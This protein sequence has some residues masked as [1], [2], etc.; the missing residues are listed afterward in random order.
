MTEHTKLKS[1]YGRDLAKL[2]ADKV[3]SIFPKFQKLKFI[4]RVDKNTKDLELKARVEVI[5]DSLYE[6]L[7]KDYKESVNYD[8]YTWTTQSK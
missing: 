2:L 3:Y 6:F 4:E 8:E 5:T 7:P 1:Y